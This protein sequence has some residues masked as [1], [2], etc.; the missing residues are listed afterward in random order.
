ML[1]FRSFFHQIHHG[2]ISKF[3]AP[4]G[5]NDLCISKLWIILKLDLY[6]QLI[7]LSDFFFLI[8]PLCNIILCVVDFAWGYS[9]A[10]PY[11]FCRIQ[12]DNHF[13][14]CT[15]NGPKVKKIRK[16]QNLGFFIVILTT[17]QHNQCFNLRST[18]SMPS[19]W[20]NIQKF[21]FENYSM[22]F[23]LVLK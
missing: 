7:N 19:F 1:I 6:T 18:D 21:V 20:C 8:N 23:C 12:L 11:T 14:V 3:L 13:R 22:M 9:I 17:F 4:Q 2:T 16:I 15:F 5:E 10:H